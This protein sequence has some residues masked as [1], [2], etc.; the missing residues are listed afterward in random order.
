MTRKHQVAGFKADNGEDDHDKDNDG[1][2]DKD[3]E[4]EDEP[5]DDSDD[6]GEPKKVPFYML[7]SSRTNYVEWKACDNLK[8]RPP[9]T[10]TATYPK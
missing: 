5:S 7:S 9:T 3:D 10:A 1:E 2:E 6:E 8:E 4:P